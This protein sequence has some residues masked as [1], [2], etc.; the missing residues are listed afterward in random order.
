MV[1]SCR[2]FLVFAVNAFTNGTLGLNNETLEFL[3]LDMASEIGRNACVSP[4]IVILAL[5]Y[6]DRLSKEN[7]SYLKSV[8][9]S[10]LFVVAL[11][12]CR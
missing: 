8:K 1:N 10:E 12:I 5:V 7:P 3:D 4:T 11:V 6:L 2:E 9:P